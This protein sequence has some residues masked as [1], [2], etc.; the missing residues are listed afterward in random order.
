MNKLAAD[1]TAEHR[2]RSNTDRPGRRTSTDAEAP[3][4]PDSG[5]EYATTATAAENPQPGGAPSAAQPP[6]AR[7]GQP[8]HFPT[9]PAG[10]RAQARIQ[11][12]GATY[13]TKPPRAGGRR[14]AARSRALSAKPA[15]RN[16][17]PAVEADPD[18]GAESRR[19]SCH[20]HDR[21]H[22]KPRRRPAAADKGR[23]PHSLPR[24]ARLGVI[25]RHHGSHTVLRTRTYAVPATNA[26]RIPFLFLPVT[27]CIPPG[28]PP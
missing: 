17:H 25:P 7:R 2:T 18:E 10:A 11:R 19:L 8:R 5:A 6:A 12:H 28:G 9:R 22:M 15:G 4:Q 1:A 20:A 3:P 26:R 16:R 24:T 27:G 23:L 13:T 14:N 21:K